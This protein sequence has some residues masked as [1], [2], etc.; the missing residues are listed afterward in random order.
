[1]RKDSVVALD[2]L[3]HVGLD[4]PPHGLVIKH[5]RRSQGV[6]IVVFCRQL[7]CPLCRSFPLGG[8]CLLPPHDF[9]GLLRGAGGLLRRI[10]V[11]PRPALLSLRL[12]LLLAGTQAVLRLRTLL[13]ARRKLLLLLAVKALGV[14]PRWVHG[15]LGSHVVLLLHPLPRLLLPVL[16]V[17]KNVDHPPPQVLQG[18]VPHQTQQGLQ[19]LRLE[20]EVGRRGRL[21]DCE[22]EVHVKR[23]ALHVGLAPPLPLRLV[24]LV[25]HQ[26]EKVAGVRHLN[27]LKLVRPEDVLLHDLQSMLLKRFD[28]LLLS[29]GLELLQAV[30][31]LPSHPLDPLQA[32]D[33]A[34][35][36]L[37]VRPHQLERAQGDVVLW[38]S[39]VELRQHLKARPPDAPVKRV[40]QEY[41]LNVLRSGKRLAF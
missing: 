14:P 37:D 35:V 40:G 8:R 18:L 32:L 38:R 10:T 30:Y 12:A 33:I 41:P 31:V 34:L 5:L 2:V 22:A 13:L 25:K 11:A 28:L 26:L 17:N 19:G 9:L 6:P 39:V 23:D 21:L 7:S 24:H 29:V 20:L 15:P 36:V 27:L 1:M 4:P 16:V 3:V